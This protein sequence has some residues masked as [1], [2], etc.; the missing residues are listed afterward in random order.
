MSSGSGLVNETVAAEADAQNEQ[1]KEDFQEEGVQDLDNFLQNNTKGLDEIAIKIGKGLAIAVR[2]TAD[3][4]KFL[5]D[6]F[7]SVVLVLQTMIGLKVASIFYGMTT[8]LAGL[9][10]GMKAFNFVTKKNIIFGSVMVFASAMG[11]LISKFK[12]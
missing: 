10:A 4:L 8:A 7:D 6:N 9:T 12:S 11:F 5:K 3:A 2:G 1:D